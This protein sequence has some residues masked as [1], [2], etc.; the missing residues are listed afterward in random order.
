MRTPGESSVPPAVRSASA[1]EPVSLSVGWADV[2]GTGS[3]AVGDLL[4]ALPPKDA[5]TIARYLQ[6]VDVFMATRTPHAG[7][8]GAA[9]AHRVGGDVDGEVDACHVDGS[10]GGVGAAGEAS[11]AVQVRAIVKVRAA[12]VSESEVPSR[13]DGRTDAHQPTRRRRVTPVGHC[14]RPPRSAYAPPQQQLARHALVT[15]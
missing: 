10:G 11:A 7:E 12:R 15:P 9:A 14:P 1:G 3:F 6:M 8:E 13:T 2:D 5:E 4:V